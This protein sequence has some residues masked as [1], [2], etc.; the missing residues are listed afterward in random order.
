MGRVPGKVARKDEDRRMRN[1]DYEVINFV[2][3]VIMVQA[4]TP[5]RKGRQNQSEIEMA[6]AF[7]SRLESFPVGRDTVGQVGGRVSTKVRNQR[8]SHLL[9]RKGINSSEKQICKEDGG[10]M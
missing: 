1:C 9:E 2:I 7:K 6:I 5:L 3:F 10:R 4:I 8:L